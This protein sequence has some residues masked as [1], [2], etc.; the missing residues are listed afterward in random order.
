MRITVCVVEKT[1]WKDGVNFPAAL[2]LFVLTLSKAKP[3]WRAGKGVREAYL[4]L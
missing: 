1:T 3:Q 2:A 4:V